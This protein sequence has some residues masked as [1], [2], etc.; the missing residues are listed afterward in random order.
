MPGCCL[1]EAKAVV[2]GKSPRGMTAMGIFLFFGAIMASLAGTTLL[3]R[4]TILGRMWALNPTA[5]QQLAYFGRAV[6]I[7]FLVLSAALVVAGMGWF[8]RRF[9]GWGLTVVI[10]ATQVL[11]DLV[12]VFM[13]H[14]VEGA[15]GA[16][17]AGAPLFFLL[18]PGVRAAFEGGRLSST[19]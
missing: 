11:G 1:P 5:Y 2:P 10:I 4:G 9:W 18:R 8:R 12:N 3:W 6:G 15:I 17:I 16:T 14:F 19:R 13:G 7:P